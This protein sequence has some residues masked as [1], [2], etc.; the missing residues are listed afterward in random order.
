MNSCLR[1]TTSSLLFGAAVPQV[2]PPIEHSTTGCKRFSS[3][4][5][6]LQRH[7]RPN[8]GKRAA[9]AANA[10]RIGTNGRHFLSFAVARGAAFCRDRQQGQ[11]GDPICIIE[12]MKLFTTIHAEWS[13]TVKEVGAE[14]AT[15]VE[16]GQMLF[17]ITPD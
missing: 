6:S 3:R 13:G 15:F 14:N 8:P 2:L 4:T 17:V 12:V 1:P 11:K 7:R 16:Y 10:G 5:A 9:P